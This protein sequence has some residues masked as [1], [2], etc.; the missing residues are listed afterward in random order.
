VLSAPPLPPPPPPPLWRA[1]TRAPPS[2]VFMRSTAAA[3][4]TEG[5]IYGYRSEGKR[6]REKK[7]RV[8]LRQTD[9]D[10]FQARSLSISNSN[11]TSLLLKRVFS[12]LRTCHFF[13]PP[14]RSRACFFPFPPV[15]NNCSHP[16]APN[17]MAVVWGGS[18]FHRGGWRPS[19]GG[20]HAHLSN[21]LTV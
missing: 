10:P 4:G 11:F 7:S 6:E 18:S 14:V 2:F 13:N 1:A 9:N 3:E 8:G 12:P 20:S 17:T 15:N 16:F 21:S 5:V 19:G